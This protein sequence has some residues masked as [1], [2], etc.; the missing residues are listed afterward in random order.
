MTTDAQ[1]M[2]MFIDYDNVER[3]VRQHG[4]EAVIRTV[5]RTMPEDILPPGTR[6]STRLYGGW[7]QRH[8]LSATARALSRDVRDSFP[9]DL[10]LTA[11]EPERTVYVSAEL[12]LALAISPSTDLVNT[13][14]VRGTPPNIRPRDFPFSGCALPRLKCPLAQTHQF[15]DERR[16]PQR[17]CSVRPR[18]VMTRSEQKLVDTM[19]TADLIYTAL[20]SPKTMIV[21]SNDDD[22]WPA[23]HTSVNLGAVVHHVHPVAGRRTPESY[24]STLDANYF[25]YA[26]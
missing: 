8:R 25:Q 18:H 14:R 22:L 1:T 13:Y 11:L 4:V 3:A 6:I 7:Y 26:F 17:G 20:H 9:S 2:A 15:L 5:L 19:L 21:V 23:I 24:A 12:A 16:C 10:S